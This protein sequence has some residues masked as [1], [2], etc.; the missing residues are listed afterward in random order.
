[1][2][3]LSKIVVILTILMR[4]IS[5]YMK[6]YDHRERN[7]LFTLATLKKASKSCNKKLKIIL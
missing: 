1:M 7:F 3:L 5:G 6:K 2:K 4:Y